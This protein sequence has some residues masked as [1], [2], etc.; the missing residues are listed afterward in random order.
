MAVLIVGGAGYIGSHAVRQL[1]DRNEEVIVIDNLETGHRKAVPGECTFFQG[2]IR[3]RV[4]LEK[5]FGSA[6]IEAVMHF[7]ANSLVGES[8]KDPLKYYDNNLYGTLCLLKTMK[9]FGV[10]KLVFSSTAAVYGEPENIPITETE[11]TKPENPY[12]ETKLAIEKLLHWCEQAYGFRFMILRYFNVAGAHLSGEIGEDH[13]PE[14]HLIPIILE[15]AC[16]KRDKLLIYGDDY[17]TPDGTCIRDYIHVVDLAD[18]HILA[19]EKLREENISRIYNLGNG[20]GF[21]VREILDAA[22]EV[23]NKD[24]DAEIAPRRPGDP[25]I[26][27]ASSLKAKKELGWCPSYTSIHSII[28]STWKWVQLF[29]EG[30]QDR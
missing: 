14:T 12:G 24:I 27:Q 13:F 7:A 29:P 17:Q 20:C 30:Y 3:D 26:L 25:A 18:A 16:G 6:S 21:S 1:L 10:D 2:D 23:T 19:L 5:V 15:A 8:M 9:T 4:F 11:R 22:K 28:E